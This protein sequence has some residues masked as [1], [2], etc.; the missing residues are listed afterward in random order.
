MN[1]KEYFL[2]EEKYYAKNKSDQDM[3][4]DNLKNYYRLD[5]NNCKDVLLWFK[6]NLY[7]LDNINVK[8]N[9]NEI[10][11][12]LF[13]AGYYPNMRTNEE[14]DNSFK[15]K[16]LWIIGQIM[17]CAHPILVDKN[18]WNCDN[19]GHSI[20]ISWIIEQIVEECED[21]REFYDALM[22]ATDQFDYR[23]CDVCYQTIWFYDDEVK[24]LQEFVKSSLKEI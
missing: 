18:K 23:D 3:L 4:D 15:S 9:R 22:L 17:C 21:N 5:F 8:F 1:S 12:P 13:D 24:E 19:C 10:L 6:D 14:F 11:Q 16:E 7:Y 2:S 20:D